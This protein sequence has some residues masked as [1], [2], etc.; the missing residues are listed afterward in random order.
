MGSTTS[1][2]KIEGCRA[3]KAWLPIP[4]LG[5]WADDAAFPGMGSL[6]QQNEDNSS[7]STGNETKWQN[8]CGVPIKDAD[9]HTEDS[10]RGSGARYRH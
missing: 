7:P 5:P 8:A 3:K 9:T 2:K 6:S 1:R 4:A 10:V